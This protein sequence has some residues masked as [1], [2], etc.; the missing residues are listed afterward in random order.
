[1][2]AIALLLIAVDLVAAVALSTL[3]YVRHRRRDLVVAY[4][5][6]NVG[7]LAVATMLGSAEV[8]L[9]LGLGLFGVLSIIR[10]RSSEISQREVS[11]YFSALATGLIA[12][13][14]EVS[15]WVA[16]GL[17]A[18]VVAVMWAADHPR[19][20]HRSRHQIVRLDRAIPDEAALRAELEG[21][22]RAEVTA[23]TVQELDLVNDITVVDVRFRVAA[24]GRRTDTATRAPQRV[25]AGA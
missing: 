18:L 23:F 24:D 6:V 1:M 15:P 22:L 8:A 10:L 17:I 25:G 3:Y 12:G 19:L 21:R 2:T 14:G 9:G 16:I 11:Y 20:L 4:L 7:V 5:G 13:L